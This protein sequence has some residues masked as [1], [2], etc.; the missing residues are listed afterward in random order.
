L[1]GAL[2][3]ALGKSRNSEH[4]AKPLIFFYSIITNIT[5]KRYIYHI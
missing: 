2:A 3:L 5:Y 4:P 1:P